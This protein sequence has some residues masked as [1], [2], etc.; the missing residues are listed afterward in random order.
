MPSEIKDSLRLFIGYLYNND[1]GKNS[2]RHH[3]GSILGLS[4]QSSC[5]TIQ[6]LWVCLPEWYT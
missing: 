4:F 5:I 1:S 2:W 3:M 6:Q